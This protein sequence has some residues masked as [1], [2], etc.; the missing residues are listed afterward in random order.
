MVRR[1]MGL[2]A[3]GDSSA[4]GAEPM[5]G[6]TS[7]QAEARYTDTVAAENPK[8]AVLA[9]NAAAAKIT[10]ATSTTAVTQK[11]GWKMPVLSRNMKIGLAVGAVALAGLFFMRRR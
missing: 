2:N 10:A 9:A 1:M 6:E 3:E 8:D 4:Y 11:A 5:F 7:K